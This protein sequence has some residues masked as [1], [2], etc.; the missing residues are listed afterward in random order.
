MLLLVSTG[1]RGAGQCRDV[2]ERGEGEVAWKRKKHEYMCLVLPGTWYLHKVMPRLQ[3]RSGSVGSWDR[4]DSRVRG[5]LWWKSC[6]ILFP[7]CLIMDA[8]HVC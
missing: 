6:C 8:K 1:G 2:R 3:R 4:A 5:Q 7:P